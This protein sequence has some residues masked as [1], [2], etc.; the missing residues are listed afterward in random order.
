MLFA[1]G[2]DRSSYWVVVEPSS[3]IKRGIG[4]SVFS[5]DRRGFYMT[6]VGRGRNVAGA[7]DMKGPHALVLRERVI[8]DVLDLGCASFQVE[9]GALYA[10]TTLL[11]LGPSAASPAIGHYGGWF[12]GVSS[13]PSSIALPRG[14]AVHLSPYPSWCPTT[15]S[16]RWMRILSA[17]QCRS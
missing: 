2:R 6:L 9:H 11:A 3:G 12:F 10:K 4:A 7:M 5:G 1:L 17:V 8:V 16:V 13:S 14:S 15:P